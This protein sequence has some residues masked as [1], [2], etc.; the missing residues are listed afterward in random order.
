MYLKIIDSIS[1][2]TYLLC[3]FSYLSHLYHKS[4]FK[5]STL[6]DISLNL[7][8]KGFQIKSYLYSV[9]L[10]ANIMHQTQNIN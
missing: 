2:V 5:G 1:L 10:D 8:K 3:E 7:C 6:T 9:C 4:F